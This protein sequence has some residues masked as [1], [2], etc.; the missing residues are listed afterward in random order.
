MHHE[1]LYT[2]KKYKCGKEP[3]FH[4]PHCSYKSNYKGNLKQHIFMQHDNPGITKM[5]KLKFS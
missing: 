1:S 2:H 3:Q 4:C 5:F